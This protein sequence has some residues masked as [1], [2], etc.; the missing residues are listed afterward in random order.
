MNLY[1][2]VNMPRRVPIAVNRP[3]GNE[4]ILFFY[5]AVWCLPFDTEITGVGISFL[6]FLLYE[7]PDDDSQRVFI[8]IDHCRFD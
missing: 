4:V 3:E 7:L 8:R 2:V 6:Q 5:R 1:S